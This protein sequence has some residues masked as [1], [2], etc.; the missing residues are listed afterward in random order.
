MRGTGPSPLDA[1]VFPPEPG[2]L[3]DHRSRVGNQPIRVA[4]VVALRIV[5]GRLV[6]P[7]RGLVRSED[8]SQSLLGHE[9]VHAMDDANRTPAYVP[10]LVLLPYHLMEQGM[11]SFP[12]FLGGIVQVGFHLPDAPID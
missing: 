3:L 1:V 7:V 6:E 10:I 8:G 9:Q 11:E 5:S 12:L 2:D 4:R